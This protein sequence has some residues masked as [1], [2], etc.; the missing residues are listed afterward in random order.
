MKKLDDVLFQELIEK[1]EQSERKRS[2]HCF[3]TEHSD[4][5]Q[6]MCIGL[7]KG[8]YVRPHFHGQTNKWEML[9]VLKGQMALVVFDQAGN[10]IEK[11]SLSP[12]QPIMGTEFPENTWHS[13]YPETEDVI[14]LEL[15]PGPFTPAQ[16]SDFAAWAPKEG[17]QGVSEFMAWLESAK[18][19]QRYLA[20]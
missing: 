20:D 3:H 11:L 13:I 4:P 9:L 12:N 8:T 19:G 2:H 5:V 17:E 18:L 10:V 1:A 6:R 7:K 14:I 16:E 15:K